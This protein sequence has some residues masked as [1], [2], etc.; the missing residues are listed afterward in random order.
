MKNFHGYVSLQ[1]GNQHLM[2]FSDANSTATQASCFSEDTGIDNAAPNQNS[3]DYN[4]NN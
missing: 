2:G 3:S 1:E 4:Y